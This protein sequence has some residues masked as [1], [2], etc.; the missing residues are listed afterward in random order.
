MGCSAS[1]LV[2]PT[3]PNASSKPRDV[4][5]LRAL[6]IV[7]QASVSS[8][9]TTNASR[10]VIVSTKTGLKTQS[11][12]KAVVEEPLQNSYQS[13]L[14]SCKRDIGVDS[15][16]FDSVTP[17]ND[18]FKRNIIIQHKHSN[19]GIS[20]VAGFEP[21]NLKE[22]KQE[23]E[24]PGT[25]KLPPLKPNSSNCSLQPPIKA[26]KVR[27]HERSIHHPK[28]QLESKS[29]GLFDHLVSKPLMLPIVPTTPQ[30]PKFKSRKSE[31]QPSLPIS[32]GIL[33]PSA[34]ERNYGGKDILK[35]VSRPR[36]Y[37]E[38]INE[39]EMTPSKFKTDKPVEDTIR[40]F[41][42]N[43]RKVRRL[44]SFANS[45]KKKNH[46]QVKISQFEFHENS[47]KPTSIKI[48]RYSSE[49]LKVGGTLQRSSDQ[50]CLIP[51]N[52][53]RDSGESHFP[54]KQRAPIESINENERSSSR[55]EGFQ[56]NSGNPFTKNLILHQTKPGVAY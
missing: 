6:C 33:N 41:G 40:S 29:N 22:I 50:N 20:L 39:R 16:V 31:I 34:K 48:N 5:M 14:L 52:Y 18:S 1:N 44:G 2:T 46:A 23:E 21:N 15:L 47:P 54:S 43:M 10:P 55:I 3:L 53:S 45:S 30:K 37:S 7:T 26:K 19:S 12:I 24:S 4:I 49:E 11:Q 32:T 38:N 28:T 27:A 13:A 17:I 36:L 25:D 35:L 9:P 56:E 51:E 8:P 42:E